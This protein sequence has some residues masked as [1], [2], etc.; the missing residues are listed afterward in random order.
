MPVDRSIPI[1]APRPLR[2]WLKLAAQNASQQP[3]LVWADG[4]LNY[5]QLHTEVETLA[6]LLRATGLRPG[7]RIAIEATRS[8]KTIVRILAAIEAQLAYVPLDM[9]YP[10]DRIAA[11]LAQAQVRITLKGDSDELPIPH[12]ATPLFASEADLAYVLFTSGSTGQPKGVAMGQTPLAHLIDWHA[13]HPRLG[14]RCTTLLFAPLSFDVHFQEILSTV[15]CQGT[16]VLIPEAHRRDPAQLRQ[17]LQQHGVTRLYLPYVAL[18]M[19]AEADREAQEQGEAAL[20]LRDVI[21]AGEQLQITPAIRELFG[22]LKQAALHNHYGPTETH[23]V[24]AFELPL[25]PTAWPSIP[26]IGP[27]LPYVDMALRDPESGALSTTDEGELLLGGECLAHGYLGQAALTQERFLEQPCGLP[28]RWYN[29]GDLVKRDANGCLTYLGRADQQLKVDG[30]RIEPG[31]IE[32]ALMSHPAVQDAVVS[33]PTLPGVGRQLVSHVVLRSGALALDGLIQSLRD[34]LRSRVPEYMI[35]SRFMQLERL[36][37]T[38]SGKIDRRNL[39]APSVATA[40]ATEGLNVLE[41]IR[42][43]WQELL[44]LPHMDDHTNVFDLGAKSL[45]VLRFVTRLKDLGHRCSVAQ[46]YDQPTMAGLAAALSAA[47]SQR[48]S[49]RS[50]TTGAGEGIAIVGMAVRTA[51]AQTPEQFWDNLLANREGIRHF[52]PHE[53]DAS[54][55]PELRSR[56]N[57]VAARGYLEDVDRFDASFFGISAREATVLD[58]QQRLFLQMC[59]SAL[60]HAGIDPEQTP[61]RVGVYAGVAN[62]TYTPAMRRDNPELIQQFGEFGVMLASEKDYIATRTANRL[63]LKGPAVSI[64]TACSTS[65][66]AITQAWHALASGQCDVALAGGMTVMVPQESGYLHVEGGMESAD[67]HCRPFDAQATGTIFASGGGVVTLKRLADALADGDTIY[68]VIKGVG[69]NNDG[70]E[71]ASFTAPSVSGQADAIRMALDHAGI[72]ARSIGY[73]EAHGT[74]TSLGDPIEVAALTQA[75]STDTQ[76]KQFARL[77]SVKGHLGHLIA[78][79]GVIGLI[80]TTLALHHQKIPGTLH[81]RSPNPNIDFADTPFQVVGDAVDWPRGAEVRRAAVSSFGVGGTNAHVIVEEAPLPTHSHAPGPAAASPVVWPLSAK[82]EAALAQ[83]MQ[84]L[85]EHLNKHPELDPA[86]VFATLTKGRQAMRHRH[87]VVAAD[88]A[89]AR[90]LLRQPMQGRVALT[91]PRLVFMFPGQGSQHP[92]MARGLYEQLPAFRE[93]LDACL[94][95]AEPLLSP[96]DARPAQLRAWLTQADPKDAEVGSLLAQTRYAQPALFAVSYALAAW[97]DSLG[98][99]PQ[100]MIGHSIGE[101]AAACHA[102]VMPLKD[103]MQAVIARGKAM[104]E[105]QPGAMLAVRAPIA[106]LLPLLP[107]GVEVAA[108][109]APGLTVL[110]GEFAAIDTLAQQLEAQD[111]GTTRLKVSHAFHSA[112]MDGALP[113]VAQALRHASLRA[114]QVPMYSCVTGDL[115]QAEQATQPQYWADQVRATVQFRKAVEAELHHDN[116]VFVEV[117]PS[118]AL[119]ALLRQFRSAKGKPPVVV[120]LLG[121]ANQGQQPELMA[122]QGFGQLWACGISVTWPVPAGTARA[123][124]PTYPFQG[125]RYWFNRAS[126]AA[127]SHAALNT[128]LPSQ[129]VQIMSRIPRL[130]EEVTR[131]ICDVSGLTPDA[132]SG[133]ATFVDMGLDSLSMTQATLEFERVFGMKM[134]FRRLM[135]DLD[136]LSKLTQFLDQELPADKFAPA[137]VAAPTAAVAT[138]AAPQMAMASMPAL[139]PVAGGSAVHQLIQQ[140]MQLMQQQLA[141]LSGQALPTAAVA[142][143]ALPAATPAPTSAPMASSA[144]T[145][146]TEA[147]DAQPGIKALVE[148]PF[149]ASARIVL[150]KNQHFTAAQQAWVDD[151]IL[152]Y[153]QRTGQSK[154]FSQANRK[155]MSDPRVVTG[156]N[157]L[158][159]DLVYPIVANRSKGA[160]IWDLDGN[161]YID[162]LSCFGANLLGYQPDYITKAMHEQIDA[163]MEIGPQHPLTAEVAKLMSEMTGME[164]VAFCNTGSEAVMGAMRIART[165]TGRKK[166]AIFNNSYHGIFDEVIVRGTKQLRSLSAAPGILANAVEN[167]IVLDWASDDSLKYLREHGHELAAIM[168]EPIQNKYPTIQPREFVRG[169]REIADASGCALIFD[170]VVTGFRVARGGAQEFY[171]VRSDIST[172]GKVIGG[173]LP[174]AA[175][176]GN[177]HWLDALDGG[178]WQYGDDSYPEAGVTYF[179]GTF[180][181]HPLALATAKAALQY[182]YDGGAAFYQ[183][184]NDRTQRMIDRLN[185][186]FAE[187]RAPVKAVHCATLWRLA[188]D[189]NQRDISLFYY[190]ARFKGLHLYEQFG[191]FV[192]DAMDDAITNRIADVFIECLDELMALGFITPRDGGTPP[193]G[194]LPVSNTGNP[195]STSV[196][197]SSTKASTTASVTALA[198][199]PLTLGQTERWLAASFDTDARKALNESLCLTLRGDVNRAALEQALQDVV[200][201]H[202]AF[203]VVFDTTEPVQR[204]APHHA[205]PIQHVDLRDQ[206]NADAAF[207][208]FCAQASVQDFPL[209]RAP[210]GQLSVLQLADG[211][212]VVHLVVSHLIFDGWASGVFLE[213]LA[214]AYQ[215]RLKGQAPQWPAAESPLTFGLTEHERAE[216]PQGQEDLDYW[217]NEL[218]NAPMP[219]SLGDRQ[220]PAKRQFTGDTIKARIDGPALLGLQQV[221]KQNKATLFQ[222]MLAAVA[223]LTQRRSGQEEMVISVPYAAQALARH[224]AL[225]GDGVLDLPLRLTCRADQ[226]FASLLAHTRSQLLDAMDHPVATQGTVARAIG[227]PSQGS[228]PPLTG[229]FFNFNP[230]LHLKGF[231]PLQAEMVE[232]RKLGLLSEVIFNFYDNS[233]ALTL[234]LHHSTEFFSPERAQALVQDLIALV[235]EIAQVPVEKRVHGLSES[236]W[237]KLEQFNATQVNYETGLRL[238]DLIQRTVAQSPEAIAVRFEGRSV[239]YAQLDDMA[240]AL[241]AQLR[242]SGVQPGTL[243]G[244]CLDRS[245][246]LVAA[247]VGVIYSGGAYVPLDPAYPKDRLTNM[248][249]DASMTLVVSRPSEWQ[250]AGSAFPASTQV[251]WMDQLPSAPAAA[252]RQLVGQPSDPA[253]VIFTSGSTGRPKGAMN[254]HEGI[255]NRLQWMQEEY[256]LC[257]QDKVIQKTPYSFDVSVWEFFWPLMTGA[258]VVV[259]K[260]DGHRDASY[261]K[262]LIQD[263]GVTFLHFVPSMLR[264]FLEEPGLQALRSIRQVVCSGE[265]LPIDAVNKF[266]ELIPH[267]QLGNLYGPTEAAV[268]VTCWPCRPNDPRGIVPIGRPIANTRMYVLDEQL[269][270]LPPGAEGELYIGGIQVGMGY[271]ARPDLTAERFLPDPFHP[272]GRMYKTGD[273]GRWLSDGVIEYMGRADHQVKLRGNR[274]ELGEIESQLM[275]MGPITRCVVIARDF[276]AGDVR[277]VAYIVAKHPAPDLAAVKAHLS[278]KLP[279]YMLPQHVVAMDDIPLLPNGKIDRKALPA[280]SEPVRTQASTEQVAPRNDTEAA[281]VRVMKAMLKISDMGVDDDFFAMGGH[282]LLAARVIGQLNKE[283]GTQLTLRNLFEAPTPAKLVAVMLGTDRDA[284]SHTPAPI[285]HAEDQSW[286]PLTLMQERIRFIEEMQPGRVVYNAPSAHRL[287]GPMNLEAFDQ[288]FAEMIRRQPALRTSIEKQGDRYIQRVHEH[289]QASL[290]PVEDLS[291]M[292]KPQ[293]EAV[294]AQRLEA[295]TA[296]TFDLSQA[297]LLKMRLFK[298]DD[299]EHA[300]FFMTHHILWDGWSFDILYTE[301]SSLYEAILQGRAPDMAPLSLTYVDYSRWHTEWVNSDELKR[302]VN[303]WTEQFAT[304][305]LPKVPVG[306]VPR[307]YAVAGK[308][309]TEWM[310]LPEDLVEKVR[311]VAKQT[312]STVSIVMMSV[313][314]ALMSQWMD[315][316]H[317]AIG[318]PFRGRA[319]PEL[320]AIMGFFNNMLPI[321]LQVRQD[322]SC[323][324]W[325]KAVRQIMVSAFASQDAPFEL[326]ARELDGQRTGAATRLYQVMFS[327][328][329]ARQRQTH[330][331]PLAHE[332]IP[333]LQ[334]GATEDLNLWMVEIPGGIEGGMQYNAELFKPETIASL[335][336]RFVDKL[337]ALLADP[338]Q[339]VAELLRP[340]EA[341]RGQLQGWQTVAPA[342]QLDLVSQACQGLQA[343]A[344]AVC[345]RADGV[346]VTGAELAASLQQIQAALRPQLSKLPQGTVLIQTSDMAATTLLS[347]AALNCGA[348]VVP[349]VGTL[350]AED[351]AK[352]TEQYAPALII[353]HQ[354][355]GVATTAPQLAASALLSGSLKELLVKQAQTTGQTNHWPRLSAPALAQ[356]YRGLSQL[357]KPLASDTCLSLLSSQDSGVAILLALHAWTQGACW[358]PRLEMPSQTEVQPADLLFVSVQLDLLDTGAL[359]RL[360]APNATVI[361]PTPSTSPAQLTAWLQHAATVVSVL[362]PENLGL[363]VA[364]GLLASAQDSGL[365]G[366]AWVSGLSITDTQQRIVPVG[367]AG[368]LNLN[369]QLTPLCVRW[370]ADGQMH[371]LGRQGEEMDLLRAA[372]HIVPAPKSTTGAQTPTERIIAE[373]WESVLGIPGIGPADNFFDLGGTSLLAM[374]AMTKLETLLGKRISAQRMV[375]DTLGQIAATYD[376]QD[377]SGQAIC[378]VTE[379]DP[380]SANAPGR[381][382]LQRLGGW[383]KRA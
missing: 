65:L 291:G 230:K 22:R 114:P 108:D 326:L 310:H 299:N 311:D 9:S 354:T 74:G 122:L 292:A 52:A 44:G 305:P 263:E 162:L 19:L 341:E 195:A 15:A 322:V 1:Q 243:V 155:V 94:A 256:Q 177:S 43:A 17:A 196:A 134:R 365:C 252:H 18:Q 253:Y 314:A 93:A 81:Y 12:A 178:H 269:R 213:D 130:Q 207:D 144:A 376:A 214:T 277:L 194:G 259:A 254:A 274:I 136:T 335:R 337:Q 156:F 369:H 83:R 359:A 165:V 375:F 70:S 282:S 313:Y 298:L 11:M 68:G 76:D 10:E 303:Y 183:T 113:K 77:G 101:Y 71:K 2:E 121:P 345:L 20:M 231:A 133:D 216:G 378:P 95:I 206:A 190:L 189:E 53:L 301:I 366:Q 273:V 360:C 88:V 163:G 120:P 266:F 57:F 4:T 229:I 84:D 323:L 72:S 75:W 29:T 98:V 38:P 245:V 233:D 199:A 367:V 264:L 327:F 374:Q 312:G 14:Q 180:V 338:R 307:Q 34:H 117:G 258:T 157:P 333:L 152:R 381:S 173:G 316:D 294:L 244:V 321:R 146:S 238:G 235:H 346:M 171:G 302:Q 118:Q 150:E 79:A 164:R 112:S 223:L 151:F 293:R 96:T 80:K 92:G 348:Q 300:L 39:P 56:P 45:L 208:A 27:V 372:P 315:D 362:I 240:W 142:P 289:V 351:W 37:T 217:R 66:V 54:V 26:P 262:Q 275:T 255:V 63:N 167:I 204:L 69:I 145:T 368:Q 193:G 250:R 184:L 6:D 272:G 344:Q 318:M 343:R 128:P 126:T 160:H 105:Q 59:W 46:V 239:T 143:M 185:T 352:L 172:Y 218:K 241:A 119:T 103:A 102:G 91:A 320:E 175:I 16:M 212:T 31:E 268:D 219:I 116:V 276:G 210:L 78:G 82:S 141:L 147:V 42:L 131:I 148:K 186:A 209:D 47:P 36:P 64:H 236:D 106:D 21:S 176:A 58:P 246:E 242:Q 222:V 237:L 154:S 284:A 379:A 336:D 49:A 140:Q 73:V 347:L 188:W 5:A 234:D 324:D 139:A 265:A 7:D 125:E 149:G 331:G 380:A 227:R 123:T 179:A 309:S 358:Q 107:N 35:P 377:A 278:T 306:D 350:Q 304:G 187:R 228:R 220:P 124:L 201:R 86:A 153:N 226:S 170:E 55:P 257:A 90:T 211:R 202:E 225:I 286:A 247:L 270:P 271:V 285:P 371:Y 41:A 28:G 288:A 221:A 334:K 62:N 339:S 169:L 340:S 48:T 198:Q 349:V 317:P 203:R 61:D 319:T 297:P 33:A 100:A 89:Q 191:H 158:W 127:P 357:A 261:L 129:T 364:G 104:F 30:F 138:L 383:I 132:I 13:Q 363:P 361:L 353:S 3:A 295:L 356:S 8:P 281:V 283:L 260:P 215:A 248:C 330:W 24:T 200:Q 382:L 279:E 181:R 99:K 135:E 174:F 97:L 40:G 23:V 342:P 197:P 308:G 111:K 25:D 290:L 328:Q 287:T 205:T 161:Q 159:K 60:E 370:R 137:P 355:V 182:I 224:G 115:L 87:V 67:G 50:R 110:A 85:A 329:D 296:E 32:V 192:T 249:E 109:N 332:R 232:A 51:G 325:I 373:V 168:T 267:A 251:V 166:I 280:P